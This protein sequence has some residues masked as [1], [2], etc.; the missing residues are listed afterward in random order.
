MNSRRGRRGERREVSKI[1][2]VAEAVGFRAEVRLRT[3]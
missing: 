3:K 2:A 1:E